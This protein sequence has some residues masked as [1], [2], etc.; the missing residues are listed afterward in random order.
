MCLKFNQSKWR[1]QN[2]EQPIRN[3]ENKNFW[4]P[5]NERTLVDWNSKKREKECIMQKSKVSTEDN[6][7]KRSVDYIKGS[8]DY[9]QGSVD[10]IKGSVDYI[11]GIQF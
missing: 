9:I 10:Y 3:Q 4:A 5:F 7:M 1:M 6:Q 11:K 2:P 8:V